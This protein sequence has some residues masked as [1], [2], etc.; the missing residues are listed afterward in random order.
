[1]GLLILASVC[2][3]VLTTGCGDDTGAVELTE[4]EIEQAERRSVERLKELGCRVEYAEDPWLETSG[5]MVRLFPEHITD[6]GQI[7]D[8]VYIEFRYLRR[9]FLLVDSTPILAD[10]LGQLRGLNNLLLLSAQN[11]LTDEKGLEKIEGIVSVRLLRLNRT[12]ITDDSLRHVVRM[13]KLVMLYLSRTEITDAAVERIVNLRKLTSLKLSYTKVTNAGVAGLTK[14]KDLTHL[15]LDG[16]DI[17]DAVI[18][19]LLKFK[20]LEF[21][22]LSE[23]D[24]SSDGLKQLGAGLPKCYIQKQ[25]PVQA[26]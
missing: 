3:L 2:C 22:D 13:P 11:T 9:L 8:D 7:R 5:I 1:M 18:P 17:T 21:L 4:D 23:T 12:R 14:L 20:S 24:I 26:S 25:D 19:S 16:T 10:G 15:G 6:N